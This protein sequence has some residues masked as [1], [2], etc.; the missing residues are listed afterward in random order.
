MIALSS[1]ALSFSLSNADDTDFGLFR[2]GG[3]AGFDL[4]SEGAGGAGIPAS[5]VGGGAGIA[6]LGGA[7]AHGAGV[8]GIFNLRMGVTLPDIQSQF[9]FYEAQLRAD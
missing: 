8:F 5:G 4:E 1:S 2:G 6:D 7:G 3:G 9:K